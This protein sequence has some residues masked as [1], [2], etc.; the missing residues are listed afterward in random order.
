MKIL[1]VGVFAF[2]LLAPICGAFGQDKVRVGLSSLS[3]LHTATWVAEERG[4]FRKH[5]LDVEL[6]VADQG[7]TPETRAAP[8]T[9]FHL[10]SSPGALLTLAS[11]GG[12]DT[13]MLAAVLNKS[14]QRV[15]TVPTIQT[16]ADLK[17]KRVG[18]IKIGQLSYVVLQKL[19]QHW[20]MS[21]DDGR[22]VELGS[23]FDMVL[24]LDKKQIDAAV[25]TI[26]AMFVA[27]DRGYRILIDV[28]DTNTYYL[29][30]VIGSTRSYVKTNRD[31]VLHYLKSFLEA[32]AFIKQHREESMD[33]LQK[34]LRLGPQERNYVK[35]TID[36]LADKYYERIPY[37]SVP[38]VETV[39][40][41]LEKDNP[42]AKTADPKSF[43]DDS[44]LKEIEA[45][46][47]V[48]ALYQK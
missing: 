30:L 6:T 48:K 33:I 44:L 47:F 14:V 13:V 37:I 45:S 17:D 8:A 21:V 20:K 46:A 39:L 41:Y 3:A 7:G 12:A 5:G 19:L 43:Y 24:A 10:V 29:Q 35:R 38:G 22:V 15:L 26:P 34:K 25:L 16:P 18:V 28:A 42:K 36:L 23:S 1:R 40:N 31:K 4:L 9:D 27:E 2:V 32:I 11:L